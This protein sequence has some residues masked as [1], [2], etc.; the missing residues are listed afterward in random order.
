MPTE[1][2]WER[3]VRQIVCVHLLD[4]SKGAH[5]MC[6]L[7]RIYT[8]VWVPIHIHIN[9]WMNILL[10][11]K[12]ANILLGILTSATD[13]SI[14][15]RTTSIYVPFWIAHSK[16]F[17]YEQVPSKNS[18]FQTVEARRRRWWG[19]VRIWIDGWMTTSFITCYVKR[20]KVAS[21]WCVFISLS[22]SLS[23][24]PHLAF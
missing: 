11:C 1:L 7:L 19:Y 4:N 10:Q 5:R 24:S 12:F 3:K 18:I 23:L 2:C 13:Q 16:T 8:W 15:N 14:Q 6:V 22:L 17:I 9:S 21:S 20:K